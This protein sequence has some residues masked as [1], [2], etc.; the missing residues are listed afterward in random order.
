L[1]SSSKKHAWTYIP[2]A[3]KATAFLGLQK[4]SWNQSWHLPTDSTYA[5]VDE[6]HAIINK[7]LGTKLKL[8]VLPSWLISTLGL[9]VPVMKEIKELSYQLEKDY[10]FDSSKI[11]KAYGLKPTPIEEGLQE[12]L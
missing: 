10:R 2:D 7:K 12:S 11:E 4:D 9:F 1:Y 6:I 5:S 8:Q 3:G